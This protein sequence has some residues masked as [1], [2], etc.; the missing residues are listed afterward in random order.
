MVE[1]ASFA[2]YEKKQ[3]TK[4]EDVKGL[5]IRALDAT[6]VPMMNAWG[7][8]GVAMPISKVYDALD[9]GVVDG[10]YAAIN[11]LFVPWRFSESAKFVTDG[12]NAQSA[13]FL[14]AMNKKVWEGLS[15]VTNGYQWF[16]RRDWSIKTAVGWAKP[17]LKAV[18]R[19]KK[20]DAGL[21][22]HRSLLPRKQGLMQQ[23]LRRLTLILNPSRKK[24]F[25]ERQSMP[26]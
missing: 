14:L 16:D 9:K 24:A 21:K 2:N 26:N 23:R 4:I 1:Y 17:D 5:K 8:S 15:K 18:A 6:N 7:A 19:A 12:M 20:G 22:Y 3:V 11:V 10:V 13:M 25:L